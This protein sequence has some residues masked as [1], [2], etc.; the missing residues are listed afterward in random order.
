MATPAK[1]SAAA[2]KQAA[3]VGGAAT[4]YVYDYWIQLAEQVSTKIV[5]RLWDMMVFEGASYKEMQGIDR[6]LIDTTFDVNVDMMDKRAKKE[7]QAARI[8][9]ALDSKIITL[10]MAERLEEIDNPKTA[11]LYLEKLEKRQKKEAMQQMKMQMQLNAQ[12]Q[13]QSTQIATQGKIQTEIAK[14]QAKVLVEQAKGDITTFNELVKMVNEAQKESI[15]SGV[16]LPND[17][18]YLN[19]YLTAEI[20][21]K[22]QAKDMQQMQQQQAAQ[23]QQMQGQEQGVAAQ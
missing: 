19:Q 4:E 17:V 23:Q 7:R 6:Q 9:E 8:Q 2:T 20:L 3:S 18:Q 1:K 15:K 5:Y 10:S 12:V 16:P 11:I 13:Q 21:N 22:Q 14:A